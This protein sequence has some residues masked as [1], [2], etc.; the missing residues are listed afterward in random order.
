MNIYKF[1]ALFTYSIS[2]NNMRERIKDFSELDQN[3]FYLKEKEDIPKENLLRINKTP[4]Y[5]GYIN[6]TSKIVKLLLYEYTLVKKNE[7]YATNYITNLLPLIKKLNESIIRFRPCIG[8]TLEEYLINIISNKKNNRGNN[9]YYMID[10]IDSLN[11]SF[12]NEN[13]KVEICKFFLDQNYSFIT[14]EDGR[15]LMENY[16]LKNS[17]IYEEILTAF[18]LKK[19]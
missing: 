15:L 4:I 3:F 7:K 2:M 8:K 18:I 12:I 19:N 13:G 1:L 5:Y 10:S 9:F 17:I 6:N 11:K 14:K 16:I